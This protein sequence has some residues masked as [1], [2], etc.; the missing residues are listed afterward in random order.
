MSSN[1]GMV[2]GIMVD[3]SDENFLTFYKGVFLVTWEAKCKLLR[4]NETLNKK[5]RECS[6]FTRKV[7]TIKVK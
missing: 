1:N 5:S 2:K 3:I 7:F 4:I 6:H